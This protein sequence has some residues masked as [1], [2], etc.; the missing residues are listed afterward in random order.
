MRAKHINLNSVVWSFFPPQKRAH[1]CAHAGTATLEGDFG[2]SKG[3]KWLEL[4][5]MSAGGPSQLLCSAVDLY[6]VH[7]LAPTLHPLCK[8]LL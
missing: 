2:H 6:C 5:I 4:F 8:G 7:S 1:E 3:Y